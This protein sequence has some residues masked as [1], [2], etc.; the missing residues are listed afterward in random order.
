MLGSHATH[1]HQ[2]R[3]RER[4]GDGGRDRQDRQER[5]E[6]RKRTVGAETAILAIAAADKRERQVMCVERVCVWTLLCAHF[7]A[8]D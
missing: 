4:E 5:K 3:E 6:I 7:F 1:S 8:D 2:A